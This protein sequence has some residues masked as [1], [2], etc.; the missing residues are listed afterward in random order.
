M[1][2]NTQRGGLSDWCIYTQQCWYAEDGGS[3]CETFCLSQLSLWLWFITRLFPRTANANRDY[4]GRR[5][6][7]KRQQRT[8]RKHHRSDRLKENRFLSC[9]RTETFRSIKCKPIYLPK[10]TWGTRFLSLLQLHQSKYNSSDLLRIC[11]WIS[12]TVKHFVPHDEWCLGLII[13]F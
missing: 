13:L 5:G 12:Y 11:L 6:R 7:P 8:D 1:Q 10:L 3:K 4:R 2:K 9:G